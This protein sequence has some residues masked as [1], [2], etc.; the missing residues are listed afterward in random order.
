MSVSLEDQEFALYIKKVSNYLSLAVTLGFFPVV[1]FLNI[2]TIIVFMRKKFRE[3]YMN[4][5]NL[6]IAMVD[7]TIIFLN[8][9]LFYSDSKNETVAVKSTFLCIFIYYIT[10]VF[11]SLYSWLFVMVSFERALHVIF[12]Y[13]FLFLKKRRIILAIM[14]IIF[15]ANVALYYPNIY[16]SLNI[17]AM[18]SNETNQTIITKTCG[19]TPQV[20]LMIDTL[21]IMSRIVIPFIIVLLMDS[22]LIYKLIKSK[23]KVKANVSLKKEYNFSKIIAL[24]CLFY[25]LSLTPLMIVLILMNFY[26]E[27][28][29]TS[30]RMNTIFNFAKGL[31]LLVTSYNY[32]SQFLINLKFSSIFREELLNFLRGFKNSFKIK[33]N[34]VLVSN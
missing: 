5:Y 7:N 31:A 25:V 22:L 29:N 18:F 1:F 16:L 10:R 26:K 9:V 19:S 30:L 14:F 21:R 13:N 23:K 28:M 20:E 32:I 15:V 4:L 2:L 11:S 34:R 12:P 3:N 6:V 24:S 17:E 27:E 8:F 33:L